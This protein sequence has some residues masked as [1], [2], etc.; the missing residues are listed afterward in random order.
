LDHG[1]TGSPTGSGPS[2]QALIKKR[3]ETALGHTG[4]KRD[5]TIKCHANNRLQPR[6]SHANS[7]MRARCA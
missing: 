5:K 7:V 6:I 2:T 4:S 1:S 3:H